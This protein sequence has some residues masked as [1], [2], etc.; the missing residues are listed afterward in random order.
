LLGVLRANDEAL[1]AQDAFIFDNVRLVAG[2]TNCFDGAMA[3][4]LIA[5]FT[6]RFFKGQTV[7]HIPLHPFVLNH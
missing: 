6:V 2:K 5:V 4:T 7:W 3:N 1:T